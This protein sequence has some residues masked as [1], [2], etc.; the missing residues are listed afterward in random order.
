M[1]LALSTGIVTGA[2]GAG[3]GFLIVPALV[4]HGHMPMRR[5]V[6]TSLLAI[7]LQSFAGFAGHLGNAHLDWAVVVPFM[8]MATIGS[9][10]GSMLVTRA[11]QALLRRGFAAL[12]LLVAMVVIARELP[13]LL[14]FTF[15]RKE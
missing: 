14:R 10:V 8:L 15:P 2:L 13:Q 7:A 12:V 5:A 6:P 4:L 3:G 1:A 11:P 9:A